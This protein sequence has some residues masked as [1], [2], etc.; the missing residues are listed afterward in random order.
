MAIEITP[1]PLFAG[2]NSPAEKQEYATSARIFILKD[3]SAEFVKRF[4]HLP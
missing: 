4:D 2:A 3:K 1:S